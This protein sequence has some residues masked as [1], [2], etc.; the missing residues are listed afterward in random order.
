MAV[1]AASIMAL[2]DDGV[3]V[4]GK[5]GAQVNAG[6]VRMNENL[7]YAIEERWLSLKLPR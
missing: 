2:A 6:S 7:G 3:R 1:K 5:G 4:F